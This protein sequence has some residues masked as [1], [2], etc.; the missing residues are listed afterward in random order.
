MEGTVREITHIVCPVEL[1]RH[2]KMALAHACAWAQWYGA[3]LHV[4]HVLPTP[5]AVPGMPGMVV[6]LDPGPVA[7]SRRDVEAFAKDTCPGSVRSDVQVVHGDP[8]A[9]IVDEAQRYPNALLVIGSRGSR[10]LER[11]MLGSVAERVLHRTQVPTLVVSAGADVGAFPVANIKRIL[12]GVNFHLSSFEALRF[13]L[14]LATESDA[15]LHIVRVLEPMA[16]VLP[17]ASTAYS[18]AER[19]RH[20]ADESLH[21]IHRHVPDV[22][23][24]ACSIT[25]E[26]RVGEPV[27]AILELEER[28]DAELVVVGA[29]D[30]PHLRALWL[31]RTTD[32]LVRNSRCPIL[33]VPTP[34]AV[35]RAAA[36]IAAPLARDEWRPVLDRLSEAHRGRPTTVTII[37]TEASALPEAAALPLTGIVVESRP[38]RPDAI[39]LILGDREQ[40]HLTHTIERPC[41][42]RVERLWFNTLR[43]LISDASGTATLVEVV[44]AP[45][46]A[47][48]PLGPA[49]IVF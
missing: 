5:I 6:T 11:V 42:V 23:R 28:L 8:A 2:S 15:N 10:G 44:T 40:A 46:P 19:Q 27:G 33:V 13:A 34:P 12:C 47:F 48:E 7:H 31:G 9:V 3:E 38:N 39:E 35:R 30:R 21:E 4:L 26:V 37:D 49:T 45:E 32:R 20:R 16:A 29:G 41:E 43:L 1:S 24:Q 36:M 18:I 22:A 14:S 17:F 25:E